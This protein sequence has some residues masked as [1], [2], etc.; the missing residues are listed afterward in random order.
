MCF[1][2]LFLNRYKLIRNEE[3]AKGNKASGLE[4]EVDDAYTGKSRPVAT[5]S[6][7]ILL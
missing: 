4:L 3:R 5:L 6:C 2:E 1:D 7:F